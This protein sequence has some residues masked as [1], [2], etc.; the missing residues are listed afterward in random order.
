MALYKRDQS[1]Y[2][3][4]RF[5]FKG[6]MYNA[7]TG[8]TLKREAEK[9]E[10]DLK[11][12]LKST[13]GSDNPKQQQRAIQ[14][15]S[16]KIVTTIKG[17]SIKLEEV[18]NTFKE[19]AFTTL[20]RYPSEKKWLQ[21]EGIWNDFLFFIQTEYPEANTLRDISSHQTKQYITIL[22]QTG[23]YKK[24]IEFSNKEKLIHYNQKSTSLAPSTVNEYI[25]QLKQIFTILSTRA[26]LNGN[27]FETIVKGRNL[28]KKRDI[29]ELNE[30][31]KI[32]KYLTD[33]KKNDRLDFRI[34]EAVFILGI[35]T[36]LRKGDLCT[37]KWSHIH[38]QNIVLTPSK[39][40]D[41]E[42]CIPIHSGLH[43]F[44]A[45]QKEL[46]A[47]SE[48]IF[49]ELTDMYLNNP[50]GIT[51]RFKKVLN[52]LKIKST[53]LHENRTRETSSKDIQSLR[54]TFCY[55]H[56][57]NGTPLSIVRQMV[58]HMTNKM[59]EHYTLHTSQEAK[60][61]AQERLQNFSILE[62]KNTKEDSEII[63]EIKQ[64]VSTLRSKTMKKKFNRFLE[65]L[66]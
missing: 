18:W 23:K 44:I 54:H 6:K 12:E 37:L 41:I 43:S 47:N 49:P 19:E 42:V 56:G 50:D 25:T 31:K 30:L 61:L 63:E 13:I 57:L 33:N 52:E 66:N 8:L 9:F 48:Y 10:I 39:T 64:K 26:H 15:L 27:P 3:Y 4:Y 5:R 34:V 46:S 22:K 7:S 55:L 11:N 35:T 40:N 2:W 45:K 36:G 38:D 24:K 32:N 21:K 58:G 65:S 17:E 29:F 1:P 59:T 14:D 16:E 51:Y 53:K 62:V 60:K 20:K 28:K